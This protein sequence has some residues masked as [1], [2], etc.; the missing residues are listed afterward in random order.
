[1]LTKDQA[2]NSLMS[3]KAISDSLKAMKKDTREA[4]LMLEKAQY[5][6]DQKDYVKVISTT[7]A[8][9]EMLMNAKDMPIAEKDVPGEK[10]APKDEASVHDVKKLPE[11]YMQSKFLLASTSDEIKKAEGSKGAENAQKLLGEAQAAF[12]S[13][14]Y[15]SCVKTCM[16][17]KRALS[18]P[19]EKADAP[20]L[21]SERPAA[22]KTLSCASCGEALKEGDMFCGRCGTEVVHAVKCTKCGAEL[23]KGDSFCRKCGLKLD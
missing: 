20:A 21:P 7:A 18:D 19:S 12:D 15:T 3:T 17:A 23:A 9:K 1:M 13:A 11:N 8:V 14:D 5:N 4:D 10:E 6:Y 22:A 2:Y 16:K